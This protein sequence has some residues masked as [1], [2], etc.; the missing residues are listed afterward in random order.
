MALSEDLLK[1]LQKKY[2]PSSMVRMKFRGND[3]AFKTDEEGN[4]V[5]LFLGREGED[6]NIRG[7]RYARTLKHDREGKVIK[8]HWERK[9][10]TS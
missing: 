3:V 4:A 9:G 6:G 8:D 5:Q 7:E 1:K 10:K 2:E